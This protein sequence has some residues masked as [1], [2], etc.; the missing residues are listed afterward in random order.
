MEDLPPPTAIGNIAPKISIIMIPIVKG[1]SSEAL[2]EVLRD[3][4][5]A[6]AFKTGGEQGLLEQIYARDLL[7]LT[8]CSPT[9]ASLVGRGLTPQLAGTII[10]A[11]P[12]EHVGILNVAAEALRLANDIPRYPA[13]HLDLQLMRGDSQVSLSELSQADKPGEVRWSK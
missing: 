6:E 5:A 9:I 4:S 1:I 10:E 11:N 12:D 2:A 8:H 7:G 13:D 3:P